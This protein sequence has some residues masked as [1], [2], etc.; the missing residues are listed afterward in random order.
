L[1]RFVRSRSRHPVSSVTCNLSR[2]QGSPCYTTH[3]PNQCNYHWPKRFAGN[4]QLL[5]WLRS[6]PCWPI[7]VKYEIVYWDFFVSYTHVDQGWA[8]WVAWV[9]EEDGYRV[10]IQAWDF[11]PGSNWVRGMQ[12]GTR[13][14]ARTIAILSQSYLNSVY[15]SIEWQAALAS[16]PNGAS[17][18]L[19]V[20]R[21]ES[22][23]RPG[24]LAP[25][26]GIDLF[27]LSEAAAKKVLRNMVLAAEKGRAKPT[28][29]PRFPGAAIPSQSASEKRAISH[30]PS[31]PGGGLQGARMSQSSQE[32][33][34]IGST[35]MGSQFKQLA[36][37]K[38][39][40]IA[41]GISV[42]VVA[43]SAGVFVLLEPRSP[44][45]SPSAATGVCSKSP[46][47]RRL[48]E[49]LEI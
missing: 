40:A 34:K 3:Q 15:G 42:L 16:D 44:S 48:P 17:R 6:Q 26:V 29:P 28:V 10:L 4:H 46:H 31:F 37:S 2:H 21:I 14:A 38:K 20:V 9:L 5:W 7:D 41:S 24:L 43:I 27:D 11:I 45:L 30:E 35:A 18:R 22:C 12:A 47:R 36:M 23:Q 33:G 25:V 49:K 39:A 13:D 32:Q 8:E 19:L 1:F